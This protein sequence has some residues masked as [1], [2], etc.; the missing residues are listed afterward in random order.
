MLSESPLAGKEVESPWQQTN[1]VAREKD[2][3]QVVRI[4]EQ[5][6]WKVQSSHALD[7]EKPMARLQEIASGMLQ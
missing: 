2:L 4:Q 3:G 6:A 1:P 5:S 7:I